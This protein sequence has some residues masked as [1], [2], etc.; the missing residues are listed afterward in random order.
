MTYRE[1]FRAVLHGERPDMLPAIE[2]ASWWDK[3]T[4]RWQ[5]ETDFPTEHDARFRYWGLDLHHQYWIPAMADGC[6]GPAAFGHALI[7]D[8][9]EYEAF[10]RYLFPAYGLERAVRWAEDIRAMHE[11]GETVAWLTL[12]GFFW[13]P[14][15][16]LGIEEHLYAFYDQPALLHRMNRDL[17]DYYMPILEAV[18]RVITPDFMT[19][20]EDMSYKNGPMLSPK[21]F[22]EFLRPYYREVIP[23]LRDRG[24]VVLV[25]TDGNMEPMIDDLREAGI[26]GNLPLERQAMV[27]VGRIRDAHPDWIMI[28]GYDK[29]IMHLGEEAMRAEFE[30]LRPTIERGGYIPSVDHQTPPDVSAENYRIYVRLLREYTGL[31]G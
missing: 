6:P 1:R 10:R 24:T 11:A 5:E 22:R 29:T 7:S 31:R 23:F 27:D 14:R 30:R 18:Y 17:V 12:E 4:D 9:A 26:M 2:W 20:A 15:M 3:T 19:F 8:A 16:L 25:D 28:G 21:L 13:F